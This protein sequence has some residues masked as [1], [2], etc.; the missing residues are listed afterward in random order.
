ME[1]QGQ[2]SDLTNLAFLASAGSAQEGHPPLEATC[3]PVRG[4]RPHSPTPA[5]STC[6]PTPRAMPRGLQ[7]QAFPLPLQPQ[8]PPPPTSTPRE[9]DP[10]PAP[11]LACLLSP[12]DSLHPPSFLPSL[13]SPEQPE[14]H[15]VIQLRILLLRTY[16]S[17]SIAHFHGR[18]M[19][20]KTAQPPPTEADRS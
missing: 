19:Q 1:A 9:N 13:A 3:A 6:S 11:L 15:P 17:S 18:N 5:P 20:N 4:P 14:V 7:V 2:H 12:A 16:V 8:L 10:P